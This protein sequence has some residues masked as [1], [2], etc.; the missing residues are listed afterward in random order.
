MHVLSAASIPVFGLFG[1]SD[2]RR[3]HAIGQRANVIAC[4]GSVD[5]HQG[6][7]PADCLGRISCEVVWQRLDDSGLL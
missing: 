3:N 6:A 2:W 5:E 7:D 1:P 4:N